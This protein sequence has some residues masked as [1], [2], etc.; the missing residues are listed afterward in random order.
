MRLYFQATTF[1]A[2]IQ[3]D[4]YLPLR[5][6]NMKRLYAVIIAWGL[7]S[8]LSI[9]GMQSI[10][11]RCYNFMAAS[12]TMTGQ[13]ISSIASYLS[14]CPVLKNPYV[15]YGGA[16]SLCVAGRLLYK[17]FKTSHLPEQPWQ[18]ACFSVKEN[19]YLIDLA[20]RAEERD[21]KA[22]HAWQEGLPIISQEKRKQFTWEEIQQ[23]LPNFIR[24]FL[25]RSTLNTRHIT[26]S[27]PKEAIDFCK[28]HEVS[29]LLKK[30]L[31]HLMLDQGLLYDLCRCYTFYEQSKL[32]HFLFDSPPSYEAFS[33]YLLET[34]GVKFLKKNTCYSMSYIACAITSMPDYII[35][36]PK[37]PDEIDITTRHSD[38]Y[39]LH[40]I[41]NIN[42]LKK[43]WKELSI[44][45]II[46]LVIP[47]KWCYLPPQINSF[48]Y[49]VT[50]KVIII[51]EAMDL[52][53]TISIFDLPEAEK[54]PI[55]DALKACQYIDVN[56]G[57]VRYKEKTHELIIVDTKTV[58]C[59][60]NYFPPARRWNENYT[61]TEKV[62]SLFGLIAYKKEQHS[63]P[64]STSQK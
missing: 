47:Q 58:Q 13:R 44:S 59:K 46:T 18:R 53:D 15:R 31:D 22:F 39:N 63:S 40:R 43:R 37:L 51:S 57:N 49:P 26:T 45:S 41:Y 19:T 50:P 62:L 34:Y 42:I 9:A 27:W 35:K 12:P 64:T 61:D 20:C 28:Q 29:G 6:K 48:P 52:T 54:E 8:H 36:I 25:N 1:A 5:I 10:F 32:S 55:L 17:H 30:K 56:G 33:K 38:Y 7:L 60:M 14:S 24:G 3:K 16:I 21:K 11:P 2:P 23:H 4:L